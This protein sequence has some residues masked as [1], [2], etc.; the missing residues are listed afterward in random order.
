MSTDNHLNFIRREYKNRKFIHTSNCGKL[1]SSWINRL[2]ININNNTRNHILKV[3]HKDKNSLCNNLKL[4]G[5]GVILGLV[6]LEF[7]ITEQSKTFS[8]A[9]MQKWER[10][11]SE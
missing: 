7:E 9:D 10:L 3:I 2:H 1:L 4:K 11:D 5:G 6:L 8:L